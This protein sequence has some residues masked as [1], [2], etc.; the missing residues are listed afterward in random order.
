MAN[1][2]A[3]MALLQMSIFVE[4]EPSRS[5][6]LVRVALGHFKDLQDE[7]GSEQER[8]VIKQAFALPLY[9]RTFTIIHC[10]GRGELTKR[11][12]SP[13]M[14]SPRRMVDNLVS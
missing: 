6:S 1:L 2:G 9:V 13:R 10:M 3:I 8:M 11:L 12:D 14:P 5:R 4:L 7:A